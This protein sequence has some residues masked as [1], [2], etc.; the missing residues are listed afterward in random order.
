MQHGLNLTTVVCVE[1]SFVFSNPIPTRDTYERFYREAYADYYGHITPRP[2]GSRLKVE[3]PYLTVKFDR[4]EQVKPLVGCRFLEVGPGLGLFLWWARQRGCEVLGVEPSPD[5]CRVLAGTGLPYKHGTLADITPKTHG[6]FD[7]IYM[8]HV[9]EHFYDP[10][11]ALKQSRALLSDGGILAVEV[12]N[13]LKPFRSL[14]HYFLR[15]VHPSNFS[16]RTLPTLLHKHGFNSL[17][18][19]EGGSDWR[20]PQNLFVIAEKQSEVARKPLSLPGE[21]DRVLQSLLDYR[22]KWNRRLAPKWYARSLTLGGRRM[23]LKLGRP[24]KKL[25]VNRPN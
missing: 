21:A 1:C 7:I 12:P 20:S 3:P 5:F 13:I 6:R 15:Y 22:R 2:Q 10:N 24:I 23:I 25:I 4:L 9:L 17:H 11:E 18:T 16:P 19:D 8:S 14:D